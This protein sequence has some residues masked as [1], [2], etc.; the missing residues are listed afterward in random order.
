VCVGE[1]TGDDAPA[2]ENK[3]AKLNAEAG[4]DVDSGDDFFLWAGRAGERA[5]PRL[6]FVG[7]GSL[8]RLQTRL[9]RSCLQ[10]TYWHASQTT[11]YFFQ[12]IPHALQSG[13]SRPMSRHSGVLG[14][15]GGV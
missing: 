14:S 8:H 1:G 2:I 13:R 10:G 5:T 4:A 11:P 15:G 3:P 12:R 7:M 9:S 6:C